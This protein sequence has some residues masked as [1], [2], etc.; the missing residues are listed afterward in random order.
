MKNTRTRKKCTSDEIL[1]HIDIEAD[2]EKIKNKIPNILSSVQNGDT[3]VTKYSCNYCGKEDSIE[4]TINTETHSHKIVT[5]SK[6]RYCNNTFEKNIS[7]IT[8]YWIWRTA[9]INGI[10]RVV[11]S[12][13]YIGKEIEHRG[14]VA[15]AEDGSVY[16]YDKGWYENFSPANTYN[17]LKSEWNETARRHLYLDNSEETLLE[18]YNTLEFKT[19]FD[20]CAV[21]KENNRKETKRVDKRVTL[22]NE[23]LAKIPPLPEVEFEKKTL[24]YVIYKEEGYDLCTHSTKISHT[25]PN[26]GTYTESALNHVN[27]F[28]HCIAC[29]EDYEI[30]RSE[31][32]ALVQTQVEYRMVIDE[33]EHNGETYIVSC[34]ISRGRILLKP[35]R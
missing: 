1:E 34:K 16:G 13:Y 7:N 18:W 9:T 31:K 24:P 27:R 10:P 3:I 19:L 12:K 35:S 6:C 4:K 5:P 20:V 15:F 11:G 33:A 26:C 32:D 14:M 30:Y 28:Q 29:N 22:Y 21:Y 25:C 23:L 17:G 2:I 8:T